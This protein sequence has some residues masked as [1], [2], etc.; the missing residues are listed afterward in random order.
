MNPTEVPSTPSLELSP[1][2]GLHD[3]V[4]GKPALPRCSVSPPSN[5]WQHHPRFDPVLVFPIWQKDGGKDGCYQ[6]TG[7]NQA[8]HERATP[9]H[10]MPAPDNLPMEVKTRQEPSLSNQ[11][12]PD[13]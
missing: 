10:I 7:N 3:L 12:M 5:G 13:M 8:S 1:L 6:A 11:D 9:H 2:D 4:N